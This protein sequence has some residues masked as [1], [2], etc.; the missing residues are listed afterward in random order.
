M[1]YRRAFLALDIMSHRTPWA[2]FCITSLS[3][4]KLLPFGSPHS[5]MSWSHRDNLYGWLLKIFLDHGHVRYHKIVNSLDTTTY[6]VLL[7]RSMALE[8]F[9][10]WFFQLMI[11]SLLFSLALQYPL[12][13][14]HCL[15]CFFTFLDGC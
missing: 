15:C 8:V 7:L 1:V 12:P 3:T 4:R 6:N 10:S 11:V 5:R 9:H 2:V 14:F 13:L